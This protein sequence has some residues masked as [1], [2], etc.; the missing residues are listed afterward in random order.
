MML[1]IVHDDSSS[2]VCLG[3][4]PALTHLTLLLP[5]PQW[6]YAAALLVALLPPLPLLPAQLQWRATS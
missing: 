2:S 4:T 6:L 5:L 1:T 3:A